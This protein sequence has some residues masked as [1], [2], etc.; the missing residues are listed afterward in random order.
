MPVG[1]LRPLCRR[2]E[3][4]AHPNANGDR[5]GRSGSVRGATRRAAENRL[6]LRRHVRVEDHGHELPPANYF[7]YRKRRR[8]PYI[9]STSEINR[10]IAATDQL[11]PAG[12]P[13]SRAYAA[14]FSLLAAT[15]LRISEAL[16]L[17]FADIT[18]DGLLIRET[19]FRKTR[20]V[21]LHDSVVA[22]L[23]RYIVSCRRSGSG[24]DHVFVGSRGRPLQY[25]AVQST[26]KTLLGTAGLWPAPNGRHPRL[27]DLRH[28][29]AVRALQASPAGRRRIGQHMVALA[30]YLGHVN[31]YA[32]YW[33]LE[34][35]ADLLRDIAD[36]GE[37]FMCRGEQ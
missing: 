13:R 24:N 37:T 34:A 14:L 2:A 28:T 21:P 26:F 8:V 12:T 4:N 30:T 35:T 32:T 36:T 31:I 7:G 5:L 18:A 22:G 23:E 16:A 29:F 6:P 3:G 27:H 15:G 9:Y 1:Q 20:L 33:Y 25:Q 19:K 11:G 10:L 17:R